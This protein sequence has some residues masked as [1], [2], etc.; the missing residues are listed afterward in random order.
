MTSCF[1]SLTKL[2]DWCV[3]LYRDAWSLP[4]GDAVLTWLDLEKAQRHTESVDMSSLVS[5]P[6]W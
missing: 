3:L 5:N 1:L 2:P 4:A 6:L